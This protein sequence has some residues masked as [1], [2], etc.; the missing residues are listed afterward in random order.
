MINV[1]QGQSYGEFMQKNWD[2]KVLDYENMRV[3]P[4]NQ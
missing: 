1:S 2:T 3:C 4:N